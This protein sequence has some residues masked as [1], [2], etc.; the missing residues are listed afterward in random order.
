M[1]SRDH[2]GL[3][4][5]L[6]HLST[7][8]IVFLYLLSTWGFQPFICSATSCGLFDYAYYMSF[9]DAAWHG[10]V[11]R[12]YTIEGIQQTTTRLFGFVPERVMPI[13]LLPSSIYLL[14][15][16]NCLWNISS[17]VSYQCFACLGIIVTS[18][19][20]SDLFSGL[21]Q[22]KH[23]Y[24]AVLLGSAATALVLITPIGRQAAVHGQT[25]LLALGFLLF[26]LNPK[27]SDIFTLV[28]AT[29]LALKPTYVILALGLLLAQRRYRALI[30][31]SA[32]IVILNLAAFPLLGPEMVSDYFESL[33]IF[34]SDNRPH[35]VAQAFGNGEFT[36][37]TYLVR[38][39]THASFGQIGMTVVR[40][41]L[42]IV[43]FLLLALPTREKALGMITLSMLTL[44]TPPYLGRYEDV[45][46]IWV[47]AA[48]LFLSGATHP[49]II[50]LTP[51]VFLLL[52]AIPDPYGVALLAAAKT[53]G[54]VAL[55]IWGLKTMNVGQ[56]RPVTT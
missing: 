18:L 31:A 10:A 3:N 9:V 44:V 6:A 47:A 19:G 24:R 33:R 15:P 11:A 14:A 46:M 12:P 34:A 20:L 51:F 22:L 56:T 26:L 39:L 30:L 28:I 32:S 29:C 37:L 23:K 13:G 8:C 17:V 2:T 4:C 16:F 27:R 38:L 52:S 50:L 42:V 53:F 7:A 25:S 35:I 49:T 5:Y 55:G 21:A 43:T 36:T 54:V 1:F 48:T 40:I 45:L 41:I